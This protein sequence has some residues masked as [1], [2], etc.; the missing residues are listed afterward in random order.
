M[1]VVE[2]GTMCQMVKWVL[3]M[4]TPIKKQQNRHPIVRNLEINW[5]VSSSHINIK[6][7]L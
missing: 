5:E 3:A 1:K 6:S 4:D 2:K 7:E